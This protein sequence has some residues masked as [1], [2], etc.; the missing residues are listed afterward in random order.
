[1]KSVQRV[2]FENVF[3]PSNDGMKSRLFS[4]ARAGDEEPGKFKF[5][6]RVMASTRIWT[7]IYMAVNEEIVKRVIWKLR[8]DHPAK[9]H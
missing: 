1:M 7:P 3:W 9:P 6:V 8:S 4:G 2:I 5:A